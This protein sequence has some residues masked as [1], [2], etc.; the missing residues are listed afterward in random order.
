M[1]LSVE[2]AHRFEGL[3]LD[4]AFDAPPGV[5]A[6]IGRSGAGKTTVANVIAG[7]MRPDR[8]RIALD[9]AVLVDTA[10]GLWPPPQARRVGYVFQEARLFPHLSV[11]QNLLYGARRRGRLR[12]GQAELGP[13][14]DLLGIAALLA[15]R[16]GALS[17]GE[18][19]RVAIGR[20]LLSGPRLLLLDEPLAALDPARKSEILPYLERLRDQSRLPILYVSHAMEEVARLATTVVALDAGRV[21]ARGSAAEVLSDP[22]AV[23]ALDPGTAGAVIEAVV[24][25]QEADG[26]TRLAGAGGTLYL[27]RLDAAPGARVRLRIEAQDVLIA[28]DR[29]A[30]LS[31]LNLLPAQV[32]SVHPGR[33]PG[34]LVRLRAGDAILLARVTQRSVAAL[35]LAPGLPV[36]AVVKSLAV[37]SGNIGTAG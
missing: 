17:G 3:A 10:A 31:A 26:L 22:G 7:L 4:V 33:G 6:L 9:G 34:A 13:V 29:P 25:A 12:E 37:A 14:T 11:R 30:G 19:Q 15:R 5:T 1:S 20:A 16:P 21:V 8:A 28:R 18:R 32:L 23:P 2:I 24:E 35:G 27:P 36:H